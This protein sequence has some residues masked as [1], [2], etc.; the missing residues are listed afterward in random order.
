MDGMDFRRV[1]ELL[2]R[3]FA[4]DGIRCAIM[5]N[6]GYACVHSTEN[7]SQYRNELDLFGQI[8]LLR[9]F[10]SISVAMIDRDM[11]M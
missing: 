7:L 9:A 8:D 2:L 10:R 6:H 4:R 3:D 11:R 1:L 5:G